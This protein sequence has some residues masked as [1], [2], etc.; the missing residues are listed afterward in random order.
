[1][2]V[3]YMREV[4]KMHQNNLKQYGLYKPYEIVPNSEIPA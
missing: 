3:G 1:M 2:P 4:V